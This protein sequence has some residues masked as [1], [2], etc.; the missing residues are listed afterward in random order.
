MDIIKKEND[1]IVLVTFKTTAGSSRDE[2]IA[3]AT[4]NLKRSFSDLVFANDIHNKINLI[5]SEDEVVLARDRVE[6]LDSLTR[7]FFNHL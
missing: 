3:K 6:A 7:L 4:Y 1:K 2:L 5:I